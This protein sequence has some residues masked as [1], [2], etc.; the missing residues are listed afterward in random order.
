MFDETE[1]PDEESLSA[2]GVKYNKLNWLQVCPDGQPAWFS[3][4]MRNMLPDVG[5]EL[6]T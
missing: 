3:N 5:N 6:P 1:D 4:V 2:P